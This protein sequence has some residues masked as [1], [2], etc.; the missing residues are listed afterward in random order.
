MTKKRPVVHKDKKK[1]KDKGVT[2]Y[3]LVFNS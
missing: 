1:L 3:L 2:L